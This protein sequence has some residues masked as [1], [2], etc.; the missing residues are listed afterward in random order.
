MK[1][2]GTSALL[3][4]NTFTLLVALIINGLGGSTTLLGDTVSAIS[5]KYPTLF[6]PASWAFSIWGLIYLLLIGF[7]INQWV[8]W[9]RDKDTA[10]VRQTGI[11][12]ALSNLANAA[13]ILAWVNEHLGLSVILMLVLL[14]SLI[15]LT[16]RLRLEVWDAPLRTIAWVWWPIAVYLGWIIVATLANVSVWLVSTNWSGWG[17]SP[18]TWT[19]IMIGIAVAVYILLVL[20]RNLR[21]SAAVGIWALIAI[22]WR[23]WDGSETVAYSAVGGAIVLFV[24]VSIQAAMHYKTNPVY[25][26][27]TG[28]SQ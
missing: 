8:A 13:W 3:W 19:V 10:L 5:A 18:E 7:V 26:I 14:F 11:W 23:Q 6:T 2:I 21:E 27:F 1:L 17:I 12:F 16:V 25:R 15:M 4:L 24:T 20:T 9:H 22:A 28:G